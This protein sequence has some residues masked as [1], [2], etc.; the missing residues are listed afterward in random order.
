MSAPETTS[1]GRPSLLSETAPGTPDASSRI[2]A[3]LEGRV[4]AQQLPRRR[5]KKPLGIAALVAAVGIGAFGAWQWQRAQD[6]GRPLAAVANNADKAHG[7][8]GA[9]AA[10]VSNASGAAALPH[11]AQ[12]GQGGASASKAA[13]IVADTTVASASASALSATGTDP[14]S[15][16]LANGASSAEKSAAPAGASAMAIAGKTV[17][18]TKPAAHSERENAKSRRAEKLAAERAN[19]HRPAVKHDPDVDLLAVLVARTKPYDAH[20]PQPASGAKRAAPK[21]HPV[22]VAAQ[23]KQCD[24]SNFFQAQLC[25]WRVCSDYW[26]KDPACPSAHASPQTSR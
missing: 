13:V 3:S 15:R 22:D 12:D 4:S 6:A 7:A 17:V 21:A 23:I 18:V 9:S 20:A 19:K 14:L 5:S 1:K 24:K 2:L 8:A 26:G 10:V 11:A 25:R 16:A